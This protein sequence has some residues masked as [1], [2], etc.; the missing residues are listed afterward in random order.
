MMIEYRSEDYEMIDW[1]AEFRKL[2][3]DKF[4]GVTIR[5][6]NVPIE[7]RMTVELEPSEINEVRQ[8]TDKEWIKVKS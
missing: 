8:L 5:T 3:G 2:L 4:I 1:V 7:F 6:P